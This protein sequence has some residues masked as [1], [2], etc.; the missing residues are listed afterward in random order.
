M[1]KVQTRISYSRAVMAA[2]LFAC[3]GSLAAI[4]SVSSTNDGAGQY[5]YVI[6]RGDESV[7]FGGMSTSLTVIIPSHMIIGATASPGWQVTTNETSVTALY[8]GHFVIDD[9]S[10]AT[11]TITSA[12]TVSTPYN[13]ESSTGMYQSGWVIGDVYTSNNT[14]YAPVASNA[15]SS[16]NVV[17]YERFAFEGPLVPEPAIALIVLGICAMH[18]RY[19]RRHLQCTTVRG[20]TL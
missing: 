3:H 9:V 7:F 16:V 2:A 11:V 5:R 19:A 14:L 4:V 8:Q 20:E 10:A 13:D 1:V 6:A 15:V 17:G 12:G 18:R